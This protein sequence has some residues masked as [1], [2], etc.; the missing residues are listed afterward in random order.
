MTS[1]DEIDLLEQFAATLRTLPGVHARIDSSPSAGIDARLALEV[2]GKF[3][4]AQIELRRAVYPRDVAQFAWRVRDISSGDAV[5]V[6][7]ADAISP[8]AK[9]LLRSERL[10]YY[11]RGGSLYL[12][13][14]GAYLYIDRPP[15]KP[16][17]RHLRALYTGRRAQVL[18][19]LMRTPGEW[20][21]VKDL[22][23][24]T[25]AAPATVSQLLAELE[26]LDW[27][28]SQG[29]GPAK[30]RRLRDPTGLLDAW[31][32][33]VA[34]LPSPAPRRY[35]VPETDG[36]EMLLRRLDAA[37]EAQRVGYAVTAEAAA[38][39]YAPYL[40][41]VSQIHCCIPE[42]S[43]PVLAALGARAVDE[44]A[45]LLLI[46]GAPTAD[47]RLRQRIDGVWLASPVQVYLD[48]QQ[49]EGRAKELA[50][51]LRRQTIGF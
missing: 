49:R 7:V 38:Q 5:A 24:Q 19:A 32:R 39:R 14:P 22:A 12:P 44:G 16:M 9:D 33:H 15:P 46:D 1:P 4:D 10:G 28:D 48:L 45:N 6:L 41:T 2:A 37:C 31:A 29:Q 21:H 42:G 18:R 36:A 20:L 17:A 25:G 47:L 3:V 50:D 23:A 30:R 51:H 11:D 8:G 27:M 26:R 40:T 34:S 43:G 13:A 35:F